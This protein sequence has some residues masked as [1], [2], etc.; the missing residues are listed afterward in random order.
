LG[1][2]DDFQ[3]IRIADRTGTVQF[4]QTGKYVAYYEQPGFDIDKD[5]PPRVGI[6]LTGPG[7]ARPRIQFFGGGRNEIRKFSYN[8]HHHN[9]AALFQIQVSTPGTYR[10]QIQS[11]GVPADGVLAFGEDIS[12]GTVAGGL[13]IV[14]G[15]LLLI[16]AIVLL[17]VGYVKRARDKRERRAAELAAAGYPVAGYGSPAPGYPPPSGYGRAGYGPP[18]YDQPGYAP[19][20]YGPQPTFGAPDRPPPPGPPPAQGPPSLEKPPPPPPDESP[21][22]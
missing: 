18:G 17:I 4:A 15:V 10:V 11:V 13:L 7:G 19:P 5:S 21:E 9:G 16:A 14:A 1:K 20:G 6:T 12:K 22:R 8:Y 2:V 3:R